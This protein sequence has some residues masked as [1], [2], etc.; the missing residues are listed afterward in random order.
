MKDYN[1]VLAVLVVLAVI[2]VLAVLAVLAVL[3]LPLRSAKLEQVW[4]CAHSF[5][6][7][8]FSVFG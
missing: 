2:V 4:L 8:R 1:F 6:C 7:S 3:V 5:V